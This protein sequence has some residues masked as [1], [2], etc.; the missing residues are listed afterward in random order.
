RGQAHVAVH[1]GQDPI[2]LLLQDRAQSTNDFGIIVDEQDCLR[3]DHKRFS[4]RSSDPAADPKAQGSERGR[5]S[6]LP[7]VILYYKKERRNG[8]EQNAPLS[9]IARCWLAMFSVPAQ[10]GFRMPAEWEAHAATWIAWPHRRH[11]WP[12]KFAAIPWVYTE[13]VRHLHQA[14]RVRILV[15]DARAERRAR[16]ALAQR[17]IDLGQIDFFRFP[18]DRSWT[19]DF[20]PIFLRSAE[21]T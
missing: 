16:R 3:P 14:E 13:I 12:G 10:L 21:G 15:N 20:G 11:D 9:G 19:R 18:T 8:K 7:V 1:R 4:S 17:A 2:A 5:A 6:C